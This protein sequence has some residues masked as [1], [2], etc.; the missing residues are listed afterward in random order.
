MN[1][2]MTS[3]PLIL[4]RALILNLSVVLLAYL[5]FQCHGHYCSNCCDEYIELIC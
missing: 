4:N 2:M 5:L 1:Q 3:F